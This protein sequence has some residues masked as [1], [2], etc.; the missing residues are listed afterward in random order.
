MNKSFGVWIIGPHS[1]EGDSS[2]SRTTIEQ[3]K[4][5]PLGQH[6]PPQTYSSQEQIQIDSLQT[7]SL[8]QPVSEITVGPRIEVG[9]GILRLPVAVKDA[10][11]G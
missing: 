3:E 8:P 10:N 9:Q 11:E 6:V 2:G 1:Q 5:L 7:S 4:S